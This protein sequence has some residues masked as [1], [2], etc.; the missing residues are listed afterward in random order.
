MPAV[1]LPLTCPWPVIATL[2]QNLS[3]TYPCVPLLFSYPTI[4]DDWGG[5]CHLLGRPFCP[6]LLSC[7]CRGG[8]STVPV[9]IG[10]PGGYHKDDPSGRTLDISD[11][12]L[13]LPLC[14]VAFRERVLS[15]AKFPLFLFPSF[16]LGLLT[17]EFVPSLNFC[18]LY[19]W[20]LPSY[21]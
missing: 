7:L 18:S 17:F 6:W 5:V 8:N 21:S 19:L 2:H 4:L 15:L 12:S 13:R 16:N 20:L 10:S 3:H 9:L 1:S 11:G 14:P